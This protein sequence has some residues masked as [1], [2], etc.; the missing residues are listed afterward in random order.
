MATFNKDI[1]SLTR[2][3]Q[4][5]RREVLTNEHSQLVMMSLKTNEILL[6]G[7]PPLRPSSRRP[8]RRHPSVLR[9]SGD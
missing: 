7:R 3:N 8:Q 4:V 9:I 1:F 5:F 2:Q 6:K